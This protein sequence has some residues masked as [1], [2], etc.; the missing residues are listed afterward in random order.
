[1]SGV[2]CSFFRC[3][4]HR[5]S[6]LLCPH[7]VL[8][9]L[10]CP[11]HLS[12]VVC[13]LHIT[14]NAGIAAVRLCKP[15]AH[16]TAQS[17]RRASGQAAFHCIQEG[18]CRKHALCR[19]TVAQCSV[20]CFVRVGLHKG[21]HGVVHTARDRIRNRRVLLRKPAIRCHAAH[22]VGQLSRQCVLG[23][24]AAHGSGKVSCA[25]A[26]DCP[27]C[28]KLCKA[29]GQRLA[30]ALAFLNALPHGFRAALGAQHRQHSRRVDARYCKVFACAA[31]NAQ[32]LLCNG[33]KSRLRRGGQIL[34]AL[35]QLVT[36]ALLRVN[37][38]FY[39]RTCNT[40]AHIVDLLPG[41]SLCHQLCIRVCI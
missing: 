21:L 3:L 1:M 15:C 39:F 17:T 40:R 23:I 18:L 31:H 29:S 13:P 27:A 41:V 38:I 5:R 37:A 19:F 28:A 2:C 14:H 32:R 16:S 30:R 7:F 22:H 34:S 11:F 25:H 26:V 20:N 8:Q 12:F 10:L 6:R 4:L 35:V 24:V 36:K 9:C 33:A